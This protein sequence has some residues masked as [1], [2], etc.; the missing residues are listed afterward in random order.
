MSTYVRLSHLSRSTYKYRFIFLCYKTNNLHIYTMLLHGMRNI[1]I[2]L[3]LCSESTSFV[4]TNKTSKTNTHY[5]EVNSYSFLHPSIH[6]YFSLLL[7]TL[8]NQSKYIISHSR[9]IL[10]KLIITQLVKT[11]SAFYRN[12]KVITKDTVTR[13]QGVNEDRAVDR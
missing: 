10:K 13:T 7:Y 3:F 6:H 8:I 12:R 11:P 2:H 9:V 4:L 1:N 5:Y